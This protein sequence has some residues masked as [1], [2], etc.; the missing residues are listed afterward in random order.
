[1]QKFTLRTSA[2]VMLLI[3]GGTFVSAAHAD[4]DYDCAQKG[5][6]C[7]LNAG[8]NSKKLQKCISETAA[9]VHKC[10]K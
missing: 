7:A 10:R 4:C 6:L 9:C 2:V 5:A 3:G 1:M 8:T